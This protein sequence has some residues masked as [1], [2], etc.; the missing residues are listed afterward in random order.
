MSVQPRTYNVRENSRNI[1]VCDLIF[2]N[3]TEQQN[4]INI[5]CNSELFYSVAVSVLKSI[6]N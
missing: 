4:Y 6:Y 2:F 1:I 3:L 5:I